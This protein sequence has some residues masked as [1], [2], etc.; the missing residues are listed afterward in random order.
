[1]IKKPRNQSSPIGTKPRAGQDIVS[2]AYAAKF[3]SVGMSLPSYAPKPVLRPNERASR[4]V[5]P[6]PSRWTRLRRRVTLKRI[7]IFIVLAAIIIGGILGGKFLYNAHKIFGGSILDILQTT[8]LKGEDA[9]RVN[10]LLAGNSADDT[11]HDGAQLTDSI[12]ILSVDTKNNKAFMLSVPRDLYVKIGD[13]GHSK[14]N[15]AYVYGESNK[16]ADNGYPKGGMGLLQQTISQTFGIDI[17]Y[18]ALVNYSALREAVNAVGGITVNIHSDDKRGYFDPSIDYVT[19][20]GLVK[21]TNGE[22]TLNGQQ[23]LNFSRARG[24]AYGSYGYARS[25]FERT[26]NQRLM[27]LALKTKAVSAGTLSNPAKLSSLADAIGGNVKTDLNLSEVR[28]LY[29]ITKEINPAA[30]SSL[31]LND[32]GGKNLLANYTTPRS[33][34]ALVPAAGIDNYEDIQALLKQL[35]SSDPLVQEGATTAVLNGSNKAGLASTIREKIKAKGITVDAVGNATATAAISVIIDNSKGAKPMTLQAL[36][37]LFPKATVSSTN[38]YAGSYSEDFV[39]VAGVDQV[40][41]PSPTP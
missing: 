32:I 3:P 29:D 39:I 23:A 18:Y 31:S 5:E 21:L 16:F 13:S 11:G 6:E 14:I 19:N 34:S 24:D 33:E 4:V 7:V 30:I 17:N 25:D 35:T 36:K 2:P 15:A 41:A 27:L 20:K 26:K 28:R 8:K 1:M 9:G 40:P 38:A 22:H 10:I 37:A 12:L